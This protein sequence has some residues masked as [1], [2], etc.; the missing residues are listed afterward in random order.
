M[1]SQIKVIFQGEMIF[2]PEEVREGADYE[3][4]AQAVQ[5]RIGRTGAVVLEVEDSW[6]TKVRL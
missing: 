6:T 2:A 5:D 1:D 3:T 4:L